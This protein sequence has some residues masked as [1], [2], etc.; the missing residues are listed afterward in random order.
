[1][2]HNRLLLTGVWLLIFI[3]GSCVPQK[4]ITLLQDNPPVSNQGQADALLKTYSLQQKVYTLKAG[5]VVS[6][7][8]HSTTATEFNFLNADAGATGSDPLLSGYTID[9]AG[10]I[11]LPVVGKVKLQGLS[12]PDA[13][14]K[15]TEALKPMLENP[16]VTLRLL[17]FR[18]TVLGEVPGQGQYVTYQ[19]NLNLLEAIA[20][21]GGF[22]NYSNRSRIKLIR[23][24][25]GQA[26]LYTFSVLDD[27]II[28]QSNFFLQ[29]NDMI[30][31]D[32]LPARNLRENYVA[33]IGLTIS[34]I[35]A[36]SVLVTRFF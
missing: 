2:T 31:V 17:T 10:D 12:L 36:I 6:L 7:Q 1:M 22:S 21:A 28:S 23:Y 13:R 16:T 33:N 5:D 15:V 19:D 25:E 26:K 32:P 29:P 30:V 4:K 34:I 14:I 8:V 18:F 11:L 9:A 3:L 20:M 24:E 35:T 27:D